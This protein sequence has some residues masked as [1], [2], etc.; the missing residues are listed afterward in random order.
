M[1]D[2]PIKAGQPP[3]NLP[4]DEPKDIFAE[5]EGDQPASA[6]GALSAGLLKPVAP[7]ATPVTPVGMEKTPAVPMVYKT[8]S[9]IL[10]KIF[11]FILAAAI[12]GGLAFA[13]FYAYNK[14]YNK[15]AVTTPVTQTQ[16]N[17]VQTPA[18]NV[19]PVTPVATPVTPPTTSANVSAE[20]SNDKIL[21][22]EPI[23]SDKDGLDDKREQQLGTNP[24]KADS[25]DDGLT[26]YEEVVVYKTNP[27]DPDTD[28]DGLSDYDEVKLWHT[29][30]L[31]PDTDKDGYL[32]GLEVS[33]G[34]NPLGP[35]KLP[36]VGA[37]TTANTATKTK[38]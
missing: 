6:P 37:T 15:A 28:H 34:Y 20:M 24:N 14:Y 16:P 13:G 18:T 30:P 27:M 25:D 12:L 29:D 8:Q 10:G 1:F 26:D 11:L 32:D 31:N 22:G 38:K 35:G 23:D 17:T 36:V 21:F 3:R 2:E 19:A 9:P 5:V 33:Q 7:S 4:V